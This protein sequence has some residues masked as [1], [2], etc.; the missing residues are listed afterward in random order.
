MDGRAQRRL[1][2][3]NYILAGELAAE[4]ATFLGLSLRSVRRP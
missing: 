4:A 1:L 3:Q 2:I